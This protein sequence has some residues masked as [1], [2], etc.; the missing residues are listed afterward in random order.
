V[1][2]GAPDSGAC[3]DSAVADSSV[4]A[5]SPG[6]A[7]AIAGVQAAAWRA[8]YADLLPA[9]VLDDLDSPDARDQW[10]DAVAT[11]PSARHRVLVA[12]TGTDVVGFAAFGPSEDSDLAAMVDAE[13]IALC[14]LPDRIR[15]GHG[16]RLVNAAVDHLREDGFLHVRVWLAAGAE[17][18][19]M[20]AFLAG[21]GW[22][23]D[24]ARREL[25]LHGDGRL[26]VPQVRLHAAIGTAL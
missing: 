8:A 18:E 16:S 25:D 9:D 2:N 1:G 21:A 7:D 5:A 13:M 14:V 3:E 23:E 20:H 6:D 12:V 15:E 24:G 26:V 11:P 10:R 22:A 4:R 19:R 17:D